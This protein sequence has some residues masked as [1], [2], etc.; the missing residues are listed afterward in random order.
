M[1]MLSL[2]V[3]LDNSCWE[4]AR[5][6]RY[7]HTQTQ[8]TAITPLRMHALRVN[9]CEIAASTVYKLSSFKHIRKLHSILVAILDMTSQRTSLH[10][11][12]LLCRIGTIASYLPSFILFFQKCMHNFDNLII[13]TI[14]H[15]YA[16]N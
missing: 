4:S 11:S 13:M 14:L 8:V 6:I 12:M 3:R 15:V 10:I 2:K 5:C 16:K 9:N 7:T 1:T